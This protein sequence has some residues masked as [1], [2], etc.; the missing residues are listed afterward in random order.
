MALPSCKS[1]GTFSKFGGNDSLGL[2]CLVI[3]M[4]AFDT[5]HL[6]LVCNFFYYYAV[7]HFGNFVTLEAITTWTVPA[8]VIAGALVSSLVQFFYASKVYKLYDKKLVIPILICILSLAQTGVAGALTAK[9][10]RVKLF[11]K[12]SEDTPLAVAALSCEVACDLLITIAMIRGLKR[13]PS[14]A[15]NTTKAVGMLIQ[16][17][18]STGAITTLVAIATM[19]TWIVLPTTLVLLVYILLWFARLPVYPLTFLSI[20]NSRK[21]IRDVIQEGFTGFTGF[22]SIHLSQITTSHTD[23]PISPGTGKDHNVHLIDASNG[24]G[25]H[26]NAEA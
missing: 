9:I 21:G 11:S 12:A 14:P 8:H 16:Y 6:V 1:I 26:H 23:V 2:Q 15:R 17:V 7:T 24:S 20:L 4:I 10:V 25:S 22:T 18:V 5:L 13:K 3:A 19:I